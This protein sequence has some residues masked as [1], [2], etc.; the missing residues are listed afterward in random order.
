M[1]I[2]YPPVRFAKFNTQSTTKTCPRTIAKRTKAIDQS[3]RDYRKEEIS[4]S[5]FLH[6]RHNEG[7]LLYGIWLIHVAKWTSS[8]PEL[9]LRTYLLSFLELQFNGQCPQ[10]S[11]NWFARVYIIKS[12]DQL[13]YISLCVCVCVSPR[14]D[15]RY[16]STAV[17]L[18]LQLHSISGEFYKAASRVE[19]IRS[20]MSIRR[21]LFVSIYRR[22]IFPERTDG[23]HFLIGCLYN[24]ESPVHCD[25]DEITWII[26]H[27][28]RYSKY[29]FYRGYWIRKFEF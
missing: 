27:Y 12:I 7:A 23:A 19:S 25:I 2:S 11:T 15:G 4:K 14:A 16:G 8:E 6:V 13:I 10:G 21:R 22:G 29:S 18:L 26:F 17:D 9:Q 1:N 3:T 28:G 24:E 20:T 5:D